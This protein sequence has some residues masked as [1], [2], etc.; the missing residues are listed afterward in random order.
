MHVVLI[1]VTFGEEKITGNG[2]G[3][4]G[5]GGFTPTCALDL[6]HR[7]FVSTWRVAAGDTVQLPLPSDFNY[8][9]A[10][11]WGDK[12]GE[13][14]G[15]PYVSSY[16]DPD[17]SHT[18]NKAGEYKVTLY[19]MVESWSFAHFPASK[20]MLVAVDQLGDVGWKSLAGAFAGCR[21]LGKVRRW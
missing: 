19:G 12:S 7:G 1:V 20:D 10:I 9:F 21:N 15:F 14:N 2:G 5:G 11:D 6:T 8:N 13:S 17:V 4:G 3:S 16:D 18:Y